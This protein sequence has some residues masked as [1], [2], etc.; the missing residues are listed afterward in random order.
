MLRYFTEFKD[1]YS[2]PQTKLKPRIKI[3][4]AE[5]LHIFTSSSLYRPLL[6]FTITVQNE[7]NALIG[8]PLIRFLP[9][10]Q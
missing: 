1:K 9:E 3:H 6:Y 7:L 10:N 2:Q 5:P 8:P 4:L